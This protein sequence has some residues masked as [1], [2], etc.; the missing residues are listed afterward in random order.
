M[1][2]TLPTQPKVVKEEGFKGTYQIDNLY[3]GYGHTLGNSVRRIV[4]SS[5]PGVG[6]TQVKIDNVPHEFST[7][8]G[9]KEDVIGILLNLK[10]AVF[11]LEG[12]DEVE[13]TLKVNGAKTYT[14]GDIDA[15]S[16]VEVV[17]KDAPILTVTDK[18]ASFNVVLTLQKGIGYVSK[19][20]LHEGKIPVGTIVMDTS[21][22]PIRRASYEVENMRVGDRTDFN[23]IKFTIETDGTISPRE[24]LDSAVEIMIEQLQAIVAKSSKED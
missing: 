5:I 16:Q 22:T 19:E 6:V 9:V 11:K 20:N 1:A 14:A 8:E 24:V 7:I 13:V 12:E 2:I 3:P 21:F 10:K 17:S 23:R 4:L 15:P 18:K